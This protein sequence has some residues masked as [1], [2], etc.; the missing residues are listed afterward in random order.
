MYCN[1][2][3]LS[4]G[5]K[6][7]IE[8]AANG[9]LFLDEVGDLSS[10]AQAKLLRFLDNGEFYKV[11]GTRKMK[12][13]TRV[14]SATNKDLDLM[15]KN[16]KFRSDLIFRLGVIKVQIP[17]LNKRKDDIM[18]LVSHFL[19]NFIQK[20]GKEITGLSAQAEQALLEHSFVVDLSLDTVYFY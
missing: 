3:A 4:T 19:I 12:I 10:E 1:F 18:P 14:I 15:I 8:A 16:E 17:S 9:T 7:M 11:G 13:Q 5:K 2:G 20:F 6:G